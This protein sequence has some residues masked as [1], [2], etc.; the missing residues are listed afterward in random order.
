MLRKISPLLEE[1]DGSH[2]PS[3]QWFS[4]KEIKPI[5][6]G[7]P[8]SFHFYTRTLDGIYLTTP[9]FTTIS[10]MYQDIPSQWPWWMM[11]RGVHNLIRSKKSELHKFFWTRNKEAYSPKRYAEIIKRK[12]VDMKDD[13]GIRGEKCKERNQVLFPVHLFS[14]PLTCSP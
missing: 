2:L 11:Q 8:P 12:S 5:F 1:V 3:I 4:T 7:K 6:K 13:K 10:L 9:E 14:C